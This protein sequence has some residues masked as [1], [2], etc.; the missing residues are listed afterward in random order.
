MC[1]VC[2]DLKREK[3]TTKEAKKNISEMASE[4]GQDHY[5]EVLQMIWDIE[6]SEDADKIYVS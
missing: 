1:L 6:D 3:L 2:I 4:V 5:L